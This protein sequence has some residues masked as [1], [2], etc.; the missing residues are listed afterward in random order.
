M[1]DHEVLEV[2][3]IGEIH[4]LSAGDEL[5]FGRD[6]DLVIDTNPYL[7]RRLGRLRAEDGVW[8][9]DNLGT[10]I[11]LEVADGAS[12]SRMTVAPG[13]SVLLAFDRCVVRFRAGSATYEVSLSGAS[14]AASAPW[15][16]AET[17]T[18]TI[19]ASKLP[20]NDEQRLLLVAL[21]QQRLRDR[22]APVT[23]LPTN[24][25]VAD[26]LGW[27]I[28]K[29]NRKLDHLCQ[30]FARAGVTGIVGDSADLARR[31]RERLVDHSIT[32]GLITPADLD[33]LADPR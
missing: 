15:E 28:S 24:R 1:S 21:A 9:L 11:S 12:P 16:E 18:A 26:Q 30:K 22:A 19:T 13:S 2:D 17:G 23:V 31:R 32:V 5:T 20:L 33:L 8:W 3:F 29:F 14:S 4:R 10:A 27:T 6:A 25:Q 7:H